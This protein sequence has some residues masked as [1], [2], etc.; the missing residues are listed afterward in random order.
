MPLPFKV[1]HPSWPNNRSVA[2]KRLNGLK[3][4]LQRDEEY[5]GSTFV[6]CPML[7]ARDSLQKCDD[8][9]PPPGQVWYILNNG[10]YQSKK[11]TRTR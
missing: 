5:K 4:R 6:S 11:K 10:V 3:S 1:D 7:S 8:T 9:N 2:L